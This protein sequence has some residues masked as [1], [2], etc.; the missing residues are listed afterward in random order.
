MLPGER[1]AASRSSSTSPGKGRSARPSSKTTRSTGRSRTSRAS[2]GRSARCS[3]TDRRTSSR[4]MRPRASRSMTSRCSARSMRGSGCSTIWT[5][6]VQAVHRG[7]VAARH[8]ALH[9]A[10][11]Q[12]QTQGRAASA[13][14]VPRTA[15]AH[16]SQGRRRPGAEDAAR[17][18]VLRRPARGPAL[19]R[20]ACRPS[21]RTL[22]PHLAWSDSPD[23]S[24][25]AK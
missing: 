7:V 19:S 8:D 23:C 25:S 6:S 20:R 2:S 15:R 11:Y 14:G 22:P 24:R 4:R 16:R 21:G 3:R 1:S 9:R 13:G 5:T 17:A 18:Q 10:L 12:G